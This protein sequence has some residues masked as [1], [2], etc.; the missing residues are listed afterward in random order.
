MLFETRIM[1]YSQLAG[2]VAAIALM[3]ICFMN[4]TFHPDLNKYFTGYFS[5]ENIYG[6]PAYLITILAVLNIILFLIPRI[7]A[8]RTNIVIAAIGLSYMI[9]NFILF[10]GCYRGICPERQLGLWLA[11]I[12]S[13]VVLVCSL[14]PDIKVKS[15]QR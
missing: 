11:L 12:S 4:W 9:K 5:E 15:V 14:F 13:I 7:W 2:I 1:K 3:G 6:K 8:K 10:S